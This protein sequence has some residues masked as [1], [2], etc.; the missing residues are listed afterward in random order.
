MENRDEQLKQLRDKLD[1]L[2][3]ELDEIL[4]IRKK[5]IIS[6]VIGLTIY[7]AVKIFT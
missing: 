4:S 6:I 7:V 3:E 5:L 2:N 1:E